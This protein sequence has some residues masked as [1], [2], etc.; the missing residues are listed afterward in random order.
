MHSNVFC[1]IVE[2]FSECFLDFVRVP[3]SIDDVPGIHTIELGIG[4]FLCI[5]CCCEFHQFHTLLVCPL[6]LVVA[7]ESSVVVHN[8]E[9]CKE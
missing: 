5:I 2:L 1:E 4:V 7:E 3:T 9:I 6:F 8:A